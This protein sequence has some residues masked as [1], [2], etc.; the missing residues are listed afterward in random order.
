MHLPSSQNLVA[1]AERD[2]PNS[3]NNQGAPGG[4]VMMKIVLF[5]FCVIGLLLAVIAFAICRRL[6]QA[7]HLSDGGGVQT[8]RF[9]LPIWP[10]GGDSLRSRQNA[11]T[12]PAPPYDNAR[13][14][15][16]E[17]TSQPPKYE[18]PADGQAPVTVQAQ[19]LREVPGTQ[20]EQDV[21]DAA[22]QEPAAHGG[23]NSSG[24]S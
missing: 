10:F 16:Y 11:Q 3:G 22:R 5:C 15:E 23:T 17:L 4:T 24:E 21:V 8:T 14:P 18:E 1:L 2:Q 9:T 7:G 13:L 12:A 19:H 6:K 20:L